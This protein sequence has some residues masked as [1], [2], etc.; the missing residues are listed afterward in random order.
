MTPTKPTLFALGILLLAGGSIS[1]AP[2]VVM[3][4]VNL[5]AGPGYQHA[6]VDVIPS[7]VTVNAGRCGGGWCQVNYA[8]RRGF[9]RSGYLSFGNVADQAPLAASRGAATEP[10]TNPLLLPGIRP[11]TW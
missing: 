1:A 8:G 7:G 6:V 10:I 3:E 9:A 11:W 2:A 4:D 5:R